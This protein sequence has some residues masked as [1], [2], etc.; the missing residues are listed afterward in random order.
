MVAPPRRTDSHNWL[1]VMKVP[2][3]LMDFARFRRTSDG[4]NAFLK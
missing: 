2:R 1:L 4:H 3:G